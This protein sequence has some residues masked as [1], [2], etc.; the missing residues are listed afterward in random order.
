M[1]IAEKAA[2]AAAEYLAAEAAAATAAAGAT[3]ATATTGAGATDPAS[4]S[5]IVAKVIAALQAG[6]L[7]ATH[8]KRP[9]RRAA[10][11]RS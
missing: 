10:L 1:T 5:R 9:Q 6:G 2:A 7:A 4:E 8:W 3:A 11:R